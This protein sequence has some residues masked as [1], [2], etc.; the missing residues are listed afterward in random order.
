MG[1]S[2][3][4]PGPSGNSPLV[5]PWADDSPDQILPEP[6]DR[7]YVGYRQAL[8]RAVSNGS[9]SD[10]RIAIGHYA[11]KS[12]GR[13]ETAVR[14]MGSATQAGTQLF[15]L[16]IGGGETTDSIVDLNSLTGLPC[17]TAISIITQ[18][19]LTDDGD[20]EKIRSAMNQALAEALEGIET[21]DPLSI[22]DDIIIHT[23][24]N[25]LSEVIFLQM[26]MDSNKAFDKAETP[27]QAINME[28]M[29]NDLVCVTVDL[30]MANKFPS[31]I[32]SISQAQIKDIQR[33]T[34]KDVWTEW[35]NY[36]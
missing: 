11:R 31:N 30:H 17:D 23:M 15:G 34:I 29:L 25:Y 33:Q 27:T 13:N 1:T 20:S 3:S 12:N 24:I 7:R 5:P 14:R 18:A 19:L 9:R 8:G 28:N 10:L 32:Q 6:S 2:Q 36:V 26:M 35:E 4:S 22:T 21:F 16:L